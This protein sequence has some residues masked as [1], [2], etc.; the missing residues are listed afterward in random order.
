MT[1]AAASLDTSAGVAV[2]YLRFQVSYRTL[3]KAGFRVARR[4]F[5]LAECR[6]GKALPDPARDADEQGILYRCLLLPADSR[7]EC[8]P[9]LTY[10]PARYPRYYV[11][12]QGSFEDYCA[13]FS[14]K[15]R[16]MLKKKARRFATLSGGDIDLRRFTTPAA[17]SEFYELARDLSAR[18][19]QEKVLDAGLPASEDF[20]ES[21]LARAA[22]DEVRAWLLMHQGAP[23]SYLYLYECDGD[24]VY[25]YLGYAPGYAAHS[26]GTVLQWLA[27]E[28]LFR[29]GR[30][31]CLDF[32]EGEAEQKRL[33]ATGRLECADVLF[34]RPTVRN[35]LVTRAH[36]VF[37]GTVEAAGMGL[38]KLGLRWR[39]KRL[40]RSH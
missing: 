33:F 12:L 20:R 11:D 9:W 26:V 25:A 35:R 10:V 28:D 29:E 7:L 34:L 14:S 30:F 18:T 32:T 6:A 17:V 8:P 40:L 16:A 4:G 3:W 27:L 22:A 2:S 37:T 24:L 5:S 39:L 31:R 15:T 36:A 21:V 13:R 23:V 19:Y 38:D 1:E